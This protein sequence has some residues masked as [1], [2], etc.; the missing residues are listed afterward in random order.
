MAFQEATL[1]AGGPMEVT[2]ASFYV[3]LAGLLALGQARLQAEPIT[4]TVTG[5]LFGVFCSPSGRTN[6]ASQGRRRF[7]QWLGGESPDALHA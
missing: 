1:E 7:V 5:T 6:S 4:L 2:L 3:I